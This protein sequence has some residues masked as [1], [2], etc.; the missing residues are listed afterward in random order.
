MPILRNWSRRVVLA[1]A[2]GAAFSAFAAD[3]FPNKPI[4]IVAPFNAG[5]V[6]ILARSFAE[7]LSAQLGVGVIVDSQPG[8]GGIVGTGNVTKA[9]ADGYT[10]L[11]TASEPMIMAPL[12]M[13]KPP[14]DPTKDLTPI[15][16][17]ATSA[18]ILVAYP[19]APF[20]SFE[21]MVAYAK[22]NPA[23]LSYA[24]SGVGSP[25]Q[26]IMERL[27]A[28]LGFKAT[29]VPYKNVG[30]MSI[31]TMSGQI[32]ITLLSLSGAQQFLSDKTLRPLA[33]GS[34][35]RVAS[36]PSVPTM[37]ELTKRPFDATLGYGFYGPAKLPADVAEKLHVEI[38]KALESTQISSSIANLGAESQLLNA[39]ALSAELAKLQVESR[40]LVQR[41]NL[42]K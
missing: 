31:D 12:L 18:M 7:R 2:L 41:L 32:P 35:K 38:S 11:F 34:L 19:G 14:Y 42:A 28:T 6:D 17:V 20:Q 5:T 16:K 33:I 10:L 15:T 21:E 24:S 29:E 25:A 37:S 30:Q 3:G 40:E 9:A 1:T 22:K 8:A 4:R 36:L 27:Q 13:A 26:M 23:A 39:K